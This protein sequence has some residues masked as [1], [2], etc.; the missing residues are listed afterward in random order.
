MKNSILKL[1]KLFVVAVLS[2]TLFNCI[3]TNSLNA[4][5]D[6]TESG[7]FITGVVLAGTTPVTNATVY[8]YKKDASL[9]KTMVNTY[10]KIDSTNVDAE[11][12]Y[13]IEYTEASTVHL[14]AKYDNNVYQLTNDFA[15]TPSEGYAVVTTDIETTPIVND[16][17][18]AIIK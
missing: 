17:A 16:E 5:G 6:T 10:T 12:N 7:N 4:G 3:D 18:I 8:L 15:Y 11:G 2:F 9:A 1:I 13:S 14:K